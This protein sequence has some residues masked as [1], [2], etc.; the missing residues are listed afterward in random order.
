M[1]EFE[2]KELGKSQEDLSKLYRGN[3]K[4]R[5]KTLKKHYEFRGAPMDMPTKPNQR[6]S[7]DFVSDTLYSGR[8]F[9]ALNVVMETAAILSMLTA[10]HDPFVELK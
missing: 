5:R 3:L 4:L 8:R 9:R 7:L 1:R 10:N 2:R 6:C